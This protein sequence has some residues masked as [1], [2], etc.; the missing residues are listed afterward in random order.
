M[1]LRK[2][3]LSLIAATLLSSAA[4]ASE[5]LLIGRRGCGYAIEN[6][7][8]AYRE[9]ARRGFPMMEAHV[10]LSADSVFITSHD[11]KT[12]RLGGRMKVA[13]MPL[14]SL[15]SERYLQER[16]HGTYEGGTICTM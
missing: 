8:E 6:T 12:D 2:L 14:D 3:S 5:P 11:G 1:M 10:R 16:D 4:T 13:S 15:R 9:G 7:A